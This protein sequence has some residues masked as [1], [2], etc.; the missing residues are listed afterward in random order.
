MTEA[1]QA[2]SRVEPRGMVWVDVVG[3]PM[4][5]GLMESKFEERLGLRM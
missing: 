5:V 3:E 4:G 1:N 2:K